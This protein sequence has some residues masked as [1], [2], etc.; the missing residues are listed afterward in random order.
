MPVDQDD[1]VN[2]AAGRNV[3]ARALSVVTI[4]VG[5]YILLTALSMWLVPG[6][7]L[8]QTDVPV[9]STSS[10]DCVR[11]AIRRIPG[12]SEGPN[13]AISVIAI[14]KTDRAGLDVFPVTNTAF[15]VRGYGPQWPLAFQ[16]WRIRRIRETVTNLSSAISVECSANP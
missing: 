6:V 5:L 7:W 9:S 1:R 11:R 8:T 12:L 14:L 16:P 2:S 3:V 4:L 15:G 13:S 10:L